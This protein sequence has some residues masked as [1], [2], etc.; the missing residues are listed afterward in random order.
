MSGVLKQN[1]L[2]LTPKVYGVAVYSAIGPDH[3]YSLIAFANDLPPEKRSDRVI[4]TEW[5]ATFTL[6]DGV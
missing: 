4:A 3:T 1:V 5:D 6:F 2:K